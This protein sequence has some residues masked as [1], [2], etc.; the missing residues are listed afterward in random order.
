MIVN[1]ITLPCKKVNK[2]PKNSP[3]FPKKGLTIGIKD[4]IIDKSVKSGIE[5]WLSLVERYVRDVEVASS[6]LVTSTKKE[7]VGALASASSFFA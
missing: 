1:I 2:F 5:V 6:N 4:V 3:L 7:E